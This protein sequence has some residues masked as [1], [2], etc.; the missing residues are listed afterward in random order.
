LGAH[1]GEQLLRIH[2]VKSFLRP[3]PGIVPT[4][5]R[6]PKATADNASDAADAVGK[7]YARNKKLLSLRSITNGLH[8]T[9]L[10]VAYTRRASVHLEQSWWFVEP[11]FS[12]K[13]SVERIGSDVYETSGIAISTKEWLRCWYRWTIHF[14]ARCTSSRRPYTSW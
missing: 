4:S 9:G 2:A 3:A 12:R 8:Q 5:L 13:P 1:V 11:C 6:V 14:A 7:T 10:L